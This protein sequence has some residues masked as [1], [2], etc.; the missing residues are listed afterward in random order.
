M[1][2]RLRVSDK[3][4][5]LTEEGKRLLQQARHLSRLACPLEKRGERLRRK[6]RMLLSA[7]VQGLQA[8]TLFTKKGD[9]SYTE[10]QEQ[11]RKAEELLDRAALCGA[12]AK[13]HRAQCQVLLTQAGECW[14]KPE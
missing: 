8:L 10:L 6:G 2:Q 4:E 11:K 1:K 9:R 7:A 14:E 13:N 12:R 3:G 5:G